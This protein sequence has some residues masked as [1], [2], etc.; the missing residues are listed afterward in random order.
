MQKHL[1]LLIDE[2]LATGLLCSQHSPNNL[3]LSGV[4]HTALWDVTWEP[5]NSH[6]WLHKTLKHGSLWEANHTWLRLV[7]SLS[8]IKMSD[9]S[10]RML[11]DL[12]AIYET[13]DLDPPHSLQRGH[14]PSK[15]TF[16][17]YNARFLK[18]L[19]FV[20]LPILTL[21]F[22]LPSKDRTPAPRLLSSLAGPSHLRTLGSASS[23]G[24]ARL[25]T[26]SRL[27]FS[28]GVTSL[29]SWWFVNL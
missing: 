24:Q 26:S 9:E 7:L 19:S 4:A 6:I 14:I 10:R 12:R 25:K 28:G 15:N 1:L 5:P 18:M 23:F 20:S 2:F 27:N 22:Y 17:I 21:S 16:F 13:V 8:T 3:H 11:R 29:T